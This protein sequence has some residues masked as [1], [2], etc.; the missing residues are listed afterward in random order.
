M[1]GEGFILLYLSKKIQERIYFEF[2]GVDDK[3]FEL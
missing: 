1:E 2:I 3:Q